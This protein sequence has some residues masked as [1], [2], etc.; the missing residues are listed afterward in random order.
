MMGKEKREM[1]WRFVLGGCRCI[2]ASEIGPS[3]D[4]VLTECGHFNIMENIIFIF[5]EAA[6]SKW[7]CGSTT[8]DTEG[9][10]A[11]S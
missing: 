3:C 5:V 2:S 8:G 9:A 6:R 7:R 1:M 4:T 11:V 10:T